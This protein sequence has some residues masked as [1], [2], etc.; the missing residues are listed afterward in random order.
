MIR[1]GIGNLYGWIELKLGE[2]LGVFII[3]ILLVIY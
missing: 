1:N 2:D 3:A